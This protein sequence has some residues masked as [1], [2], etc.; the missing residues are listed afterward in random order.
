NPW[1]RRETVTSPGGT[2]KTAVVER[3]ID[4]NGNLLQTKEYDWVGYDASGPEVGTTVRRVT[5]LTYNAV[6]PSADSA[7][8]ADESMAYWNPDFM[9]AQARRLNAVARREIF[10]GNGTAAA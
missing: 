8:V 6:V 7:V 5:N 1:V 9:P 2:P 10:D 3:L 4:K